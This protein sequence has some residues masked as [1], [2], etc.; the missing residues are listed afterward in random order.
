MITDNRTP[1]RTIRRSPML[2]HRIVMS[3]DGKIW[4]PGLISYIFPIDDRIWA[5]LRLSGR[6][7]ARIVG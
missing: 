5:A 7:R 1:P 3:F 6:G 4:T 2:R